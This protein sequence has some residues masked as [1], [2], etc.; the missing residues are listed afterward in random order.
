[1]RLRDSIHLVRHRSK[2]LTVGFIDQ[3]ALGGALP[4]YTPIIDKSGFWKVTSESAVVAGTVVDRTGNTAICDTGTTL[5]LVDESLCESIYAQIPGATYYIPPQVHQADANCS[6]Y[7]SQLGGYI[8]PESS[9]S[10]LPI[11]EIGLGDPN[12]GEQR[13]GLYP[14]DIAFAEAK[15]G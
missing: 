1:M 6:R 14:A 3:D 15:T 5:C 7:D 4:F 2:I 10:S 11:V 9:T 8:F 12:N 13:F